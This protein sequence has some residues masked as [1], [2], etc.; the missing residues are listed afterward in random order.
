[1]LGAFSRTG[2]LALAVAACQTTSRGTTDAGA[3]ATTR[4]A[5]TASASVRV[6]PPAPPPVESIDVPLCRVIAI[7]PAPGAPADAGSDANAPA[8]G[9]ALERRDW[10]E[11]GANTELV[12]RH[13]A[14]TRELALRGP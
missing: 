7:R 1:M 3:S 13:A 10:L 11:L 12:L 6:P 8:V 4:N 9:A 5:G 2:A 14:T